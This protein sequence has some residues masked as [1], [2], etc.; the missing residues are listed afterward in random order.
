ML[1]PHSPYMAR[2]SSVLGIYICQAV[3][4]RDLGLKD[5]GSPQHK[6]SLL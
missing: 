5:T 2:K 6:A 4:G 1:N 3:G